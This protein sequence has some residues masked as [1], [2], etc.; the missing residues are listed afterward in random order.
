MDTYFTY[1][2]ARGKVTLGASDGML[3]RLVPGE[4]ALV[5]EMRPSAVTNDAANQLMEYLAGRRRLF[6]LPLE[7]R[8]TPFQLEVWHA[9]ERIPYGETRTYSQVA[10]EIG[11]PGASRAVG[12]ANRA[13]PIPIIVPCH[14]VVP[15]SGGVGD[16]A[17]GP[18]MKRFLLRLEGLHR[19]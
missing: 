3:V 6:E 5:G 18:D 14:R 17:F 11:R 15:A 16:Y 7:L 8:G 1:R 2:T 12:S 13:N 19:M 10:A 4:V 9:L